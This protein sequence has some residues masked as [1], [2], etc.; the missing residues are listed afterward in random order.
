[1][2]D[3]EIPEADPRSDLDQDEKLEV[4]GGTLVWRDPVASGK[5]FRGAY[6][7]PILLIGLI[8]LLIAWVL[9]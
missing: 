1:M 4:D 5:P 7:W 3:E 2:S 9:A 8:I 6:L